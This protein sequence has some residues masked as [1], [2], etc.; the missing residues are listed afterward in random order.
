MSDMD[1]ITKAL[2]QKY[3]GGLSLDEKKK[4][5]PA[6]VSSNT[7]SYSGSTQR[8]SQTQTRADDHNTERS[9]HFG[10]SPRVFPSEKMELRSWKN[11]SSVIPKRPP[12]L[13]S[14]FS[15]EELD[16]M[17][18][19]PAKRGWEFSV[20]L[21]VIGLPLDLHE[22]HDF[23]IYGWMARAFLDRKREAHQR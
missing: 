10:T 23:T 2:A 13:I 12:V 3:S 14:Q 20:W 9:H 19:T 8:S 7:S 18:K 11:H 4:P 16:T 1:E 6:P 21:E 15:D 17:M 22:K 5:A